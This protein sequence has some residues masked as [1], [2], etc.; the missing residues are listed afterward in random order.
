[1]VDLSSAMNGFAWPLG[2]LLA[3]L[4]GEC[5]SR[6]LHLPRI[7]AY[8]L[9][10]FVL[11]PAQTGFLPSSQQPSMLLLANIA[12]GLLLF[13]CG[14]RINLRW[15]R[16]NPWIT[17]TG[18]AEAALTFV[19][20]YALA[21]GTGLSA[22]A[23][24]L[25]AALSMATSPATVVRVLNEERSSGQV[26]ERVLHLSALNCALAVLVFKLLVGVVILRTSGSL[27]EAASVSV[28]LLAASVVLGAA[29]GALVSVLLNST[30]S[31]AQD[32]T[33]AFG[34]A[35]ILVVSIAHSLALSPVLATLGF[36]LAARHRRLVLSRTQRGFGPLGDV[37]SVLLFVFV[38]A[39]LDYRDVLAGLGLGAGLMVVRQ[40]AKLAGVCLFAHLSGIS[41]RKG[42]YCGLAM[43]P[44]SAFVILVLE[45][46]RHIGIELLENFAPLAAAALLLE[47]I[48]PLMTQRALVH[49]GE[50]RE[51]R[52]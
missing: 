14:Y 24:M 23:S 18:L 8:A 19:A 46:T 42:A 31:A 13:E 21:N 27:W 39:T 5:A 36:G 52:E 28:G 32:S 29:A 48:G 2:L 30:R 9:V 3:W 16:A 11:A 35:V 38:A 41:W 45:Q 47:I 43:A 40:L 6:W 49:S 33:L 34:L 1:M 12:L 51:S 25:L 7:S 37:M 17:V 44:L 50:A 22:I 4:A 26:S 20:V 10:G 15:L